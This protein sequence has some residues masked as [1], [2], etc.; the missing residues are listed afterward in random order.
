MRKVIT[1]S[2]A[3]TLLSG[4]F[5]VGFD[6]AAEAKGK[7]INKRQNHQRSRIKQGVKSGELTKIEAKR[8]KAQQ[9]AFAKR[10]QAMRK[11]GDGLSKAEKA[12]LNKRQDELS[13][14]IYRQKHDDKDRN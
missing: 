1:L 9:K 11:S 10:E 6:Q 5:L 3:A 7:Y 13:K 4:M 2:V 14:N 8:M 12:V